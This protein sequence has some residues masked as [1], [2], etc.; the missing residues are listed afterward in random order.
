MHCAGCAA[1]L[2]TVL[3][4][5]EGV[6]EA[7]VNFATS[8]A[9]VRGRDALPN[10]R[11]VR[12]AIETAGFQGRCLDGNLVE[13][14]FVDI[15]NSEVNTARLI[16]A[17][18]GF[19]P[20]AFV[21]ML[22]HFSH[23]FVWLHSFPGKIWVEAVI[24]AAVV[25][26]AASGILRS[27]WAALR[28][29]APDMDLLVGAGAVLAWCGSVVEILLRAEVHQ[30]TYFEAAAGIVTF[31]LLGR[32]L[33]GGTRRKASEAV[34]ALAQLQPG[35]VQVEFEGETR[36]V[37]LSEVREGMVVQVAPGE[38][39]PVDGLV[40]EGVSTADESWVSGESVPVPVTVGSLVTGGTLNGDGALR[41]RVT[42]A[43]RD[44]F[45]QQV[46]RIVGDAQATK[47][48]VQKLADVVS[49]H[50]CV[51]VVLAS[52]ITAT[53]WA[54]FGPEATRWSDAF[55]H[56]LSV[57]VVACPCALGLATP[58]AVLAGT[59][60]AAQLGILFRN[61]AV[62][63]VL[64]K[65]R[66]VVFDK[67]GTLTFGRL[68][69][70]EWWE[71][72]SFNGR[73][74]ALV[75]A[76]EKQSL[77]PA[78]AAVV[79]VASERGLPVGRAHG[80]TAIPGNGLKAKVDDMELLVGTAPWLESCGVILPDTSPAE[81]AARI[82]IATD[83]EFAGWFRVSDELRPEAVAVVAELKK[84][85]IT[86]VLLSGDRPEIAVE[87]AKQAGIEEVVA[88]VTPDAK[89][90]YVKRLQ[91]SGPVVMVG[92]G[93]ND[94]PALAQADVGVAMGGGTAAAR[95]TAD[96]TLIRDDLN[97]LLHAI[98]LSKK[99]LNVIRE[100]LLLA[101][102]YNVLALPLAA[103][104]LEVWHGWAPG[105]VAASAAMALSSVSVVLNA[106]RLRH[107]LR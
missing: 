1:R 46:L 51:A 33:E 63:E 88:D 106:V 98:L 21:T 58:V 24:S 22:G 32:W 57:L 100:N 107:F 80:V 70:V 66:T 45:L 3:R 17:L 26:G 77:H 7:G 11:H 99:T 5:L 16:G 14:S 12:E 40:L 104:L 47:P 13:N 69:V 62:L 29:G 83:G 94:T 78:A 71:R 84:Q 52:L 82:W 38:R 30:G 68:R 97:S 105:P 61:G 59:G 102:G 91:L 10:S 85:G 8:Q 15:P 56:G 67:T 37:E 48:P 28:R 55:R 79:A 18:V 76:A 50:F 65:A 49:G 41:V 64:S 35:T 75:A 72:R 19:V 4:G 44:A 27:A 92:D 39:I 95:Q 87:I 60:R 36:S 43:G 42:A 6:A 54:V 9:S 34:R 96:V 93:V 2:E 20:L 89:L 73:L 25:F 101:F 86:A 74:L 53:A 31:A 81:R 103:G 90:E 23:H